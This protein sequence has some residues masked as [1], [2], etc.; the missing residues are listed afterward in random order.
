MTSIISSIAIAEIESKSDAELFAELRDLIA[1]TADHVRRLSVVWFA[2]EKRG[3]DLSA[4]RTGIGRHLSAVAL[5]RIAPE[6]VVRLAGNATAMR[7]LAHLPVAEQQRILE[8]GTIK[9]NRAGEIVDVPVAS[10]TAAD[11]SRAFDPIEGRLLPPGE[12]RTSRQIR[13]RP[14]RTRRIVVEL[15]DDQHTK[16]QGEAART[17]KSASALV[18]QLLKNEG[19]I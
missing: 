7:A 9:I 6:A 19:A 4:L 2:L 15:T 18:I 14:A 3:H 10:L 11:V 8:L 13:S 16:L 1:V 12:Q 17:N 5:G